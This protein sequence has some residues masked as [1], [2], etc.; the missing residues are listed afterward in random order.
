MIDEIS[1][2]A[3]LEIMRLQVVIDDCV[4]DGI[5]V[6]SCALTSADRINKKAVQKQGSC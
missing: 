2:L 6:I 4:E 5:N 1:A 3:K